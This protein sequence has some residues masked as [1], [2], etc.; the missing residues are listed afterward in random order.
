MG[1]IAIG[2]GI[3]S[4]IPYL[5]TILKGRT[6]PHAFSW[7]IWGIL[8]A[9]AF[10]AQI[11]GGGGVGAWV[12]GF[13]AATSLIIVALALFKG[14]KNVTK[15]DWLTFVTALLAIPLWYFTKNPLNAVILITII[16]ALAFYPTFRKSWHRPYEENAFTF[17]LS[18]IKFI[19]AT[20]ALET[21]NITT[22]LYPLSLVFM[23]GVF[24]IMILWRR[25][26]LKN[27]TH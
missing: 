14:E 4:Y 15:S 17:T 6:K 12:T 16:D 20:L 2:I 27:G 8:T 7:L 3:I 5:L 24:V 21:L 9:I 26:A 11:T 22:S 10:A 1:A 23:N 19:F 18:G 25:K 13:T